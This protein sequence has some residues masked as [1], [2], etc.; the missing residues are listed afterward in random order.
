[1]KYCPKCNTDYPDNLYVC[2]VCRSPLRKKNE[3]QT[4]DG[5][6]NANAQVKVKTASVTSYEDE[7]NR[8]N[9]EEN[10]I[11]GQV[12]K[13]I[14]D[15]V[16]TA[17]EKSAE[18]MKKVNEDPEFRHKVADGLRICGETLGC[19]AEIIHIVNEVKKGSS[20]ENSNQKNSEH[21]ETQNYN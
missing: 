21:D 2:K 18:F 4:K 6:Q 19:I 7:Y 8:L 10:S 16:N 5:T 17:S 15:T 12:G 14:K 3:V 11:V 1:M 20:S 9:S 13:S